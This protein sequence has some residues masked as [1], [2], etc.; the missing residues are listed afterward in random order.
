MVMRGKT[1]QVKLL[2]GGLLVL[3]LI[4]C[5]TRADDASATQQQLQ[6][7]QQQNEK[8]QQQLQKQQ[9]LIDSLARKVSEIQNA[10]SNRDAAMTDLKAEMKDQA[11]QTPAS[12]SQLFGKVHI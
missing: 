5:N 11:D 12:A 2:S 1:T 7:L 3:F 4:A 10:S 8:L 6:L 9:E